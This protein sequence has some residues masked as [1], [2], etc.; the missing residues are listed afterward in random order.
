MVGA[1][2]RG[3]EKSTAESRP[4]FALSSCFFAVRCVK[5]MV[6]LTSAVHVYARWRVIKERR[7]STSNVN[8]AVLWWLL[9]VPFLAPIM[10]ALKITRLVS[11]NHAISMLTSASFASTIVQR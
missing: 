9:P 3:P 2:K 7:V 10:S 8:I 4:R 5:L 11:A 1:K 6:A